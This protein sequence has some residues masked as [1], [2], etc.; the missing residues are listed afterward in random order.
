LVSFHPI[1]RENL[2]FKL[3]ILLIT[4]SFETCVRCKNSGQ[5]WWFK[6]ALL[7]FHESWGPHLD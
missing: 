7:K 6:H 4:R 1:S 5:N 3:F 2:Q